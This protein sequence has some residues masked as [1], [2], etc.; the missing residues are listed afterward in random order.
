MFARFFITYKTSLMSNIQSTN[1]DDQ[2]ENDLNDVQSENIVIKS[3][4]D[5][6]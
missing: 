3:P 2:S 1:R 6:K 4:N 5:Q